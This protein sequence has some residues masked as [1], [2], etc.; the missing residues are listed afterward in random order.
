MLFTIIPNKNTRKKHQVF[1]HEKV[2]N[3][4]KSWFTNKKI[5]IIPTHAVHVQ[6][7]Y[8]YLIWVIKV[9]IPY[10]DPMGIWAES[11]RE[12]Q[13]TIFS[14]HR[15]QVTVPRNRQGGGCDCGWGCGCWKACAYT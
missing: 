11:R 2:T 7:I 3:N 5:P 4:K 9:N 13:D 15:F 10:T 8:V 1:T 14:S 6:Y 12:D